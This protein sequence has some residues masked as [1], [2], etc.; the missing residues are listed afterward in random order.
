MVVAPASRHFIM[1]DNP[2]WFHSA[3]SDFLKA[4]GK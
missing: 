2:A 3:V 4:H 1:L